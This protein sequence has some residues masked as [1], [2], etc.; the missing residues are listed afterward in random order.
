MFRFYLCQ[1]VFQKRVL[2]PF[3]NFSDKLRFSGVVKTVQK[4][5]VSVAQFN[6]IFT[7]IDVRSCFKNTIL[8]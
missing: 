7:D 3:F 6:G 8:R 1:Q 2:Y 4:I 5:A